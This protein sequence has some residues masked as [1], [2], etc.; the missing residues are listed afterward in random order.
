MTGDGASWICLPYEQRITTD[1]GDIEIGRIVE[2][3]LNVKVLSYNHE[4]ETVEWDSIESYQEN[5]FRE[6]V[7]IELECGIILTC[8]EDHEV[9]VIGK[10]YILAK[11]IQPDDE[12]IRWDVSTKL[13]SP[14]ESPI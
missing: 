8:T 11:D 9:F 6:L 14:V 5:P 3:K 13:T 12:V 4:E 2:E 10:G 7:E 1:T